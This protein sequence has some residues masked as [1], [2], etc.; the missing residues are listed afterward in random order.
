LAVGAPGIS[1]GSNGAFGYICLFKNGELNFMAKSDDDDY[2]DTSSVFRFR[3]EIRS[4]ATSAI[5]V[6]SATLSQSG[7]ST[8]SVRSG[9]LQSI[10]SVR[11]PKS[12]MGNAR[13]F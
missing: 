1:L 11:S 6:A 7:R 9:F 10:K 4:N 8:F 5:D 3:Q 2:F 13:T 12:L